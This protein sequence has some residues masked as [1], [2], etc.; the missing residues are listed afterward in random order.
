M[1]VSLVSH[2]SEP[3]PCVIRAISGSP[4]T[5]S[6]I[7]VFLCLKGCIPKL[8]DDY[9]IYSESAIT[10]QVS[11]LSG[12]AKSAFVFSLIKQVSALDEMTLQTRL[13]QRTNY[14]LKY[15]QNS[16]SI[17]DNLSLTDQ[18]WINNEYIYTRAGE[19]ISG[20]FEPSKVMPFIWLPVLQFFSDS[21]Y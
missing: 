6:I 13:K 4:G 16:L 8:P 11:C 2:T 15:K 19:K 17:G 9:T 21:L 12:E 20:F 1:P 7:S 10:R 3:Y 5:M 18:N 14:R